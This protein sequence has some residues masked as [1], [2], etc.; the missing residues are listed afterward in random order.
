MTRLNLDASRWLLGLEALVCLGPLTLIW[1]AVTHMIFTAQVLDP[2]VW[3]PTLIG[4]LGPVALLLAL[5]TIALRRPVSGAPFALLAVSFAVLAVVHIL[6]LAQP[7]FDFDWRAWMLISV[8]P[9][10]ACAHL[11][12]IGSR[13]NGSSSYASQSVK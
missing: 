4:T 8:L 5:F 13:V 10:I 12:L 6:P 3:V 2:M 9:C 1:M 11:A 7:W